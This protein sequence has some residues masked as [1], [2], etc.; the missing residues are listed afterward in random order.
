MDRE[1]EEEEPTKGERKEN[2]KTTDR[3]ITLGPFHF[4]QKKMS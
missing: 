2:K 4:I 3:W 1:E